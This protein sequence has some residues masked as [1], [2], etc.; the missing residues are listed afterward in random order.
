MNLCVGFDLDMTLIDPRPGMVDVVE[1]LG[2]DAGITLDAEGFAEA[3]GPP[4]HVALLAAGA[5]EDRIAELVPRFRALYP[6]FVIPRTVAMPGAAEAIAAVRDAGGKVIVIT[7]K[8]RKNAVLHLDEL[9]FAV[10]AVIGELWAE[11][12]AVALRENHATVYVGDHL[13]DMRGAQAAGATAVGVTS[14][15]CSRQELLDAGADIVLPGL[16][17]FPAW[18]ADRQA[19]TGQIA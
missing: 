1:A 6:K 5:P 16:T 9:G 15:P 14:G 10:D 17:G 12:K 8:Y 18:L 11:A 4:L 19:L 7:G 2:V 13:G 3:L